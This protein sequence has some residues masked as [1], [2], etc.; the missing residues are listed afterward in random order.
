MELFI[1]KQLQ[2]FSN[3]FFDMFFQGITILGEE[4][5]ILLF[6]VILYW[7]INKDLGKF[8]GYTFFISLLINTSLKEFFHTTRPIGIDGIRSLRTSTAIGYSFPSGH[9]QA[10]TTLFASLSIYL[11]RRF[12]YIVSI[13]LIVFVGISRV[14]LGLHWPRDVIGAIIIALIIVLVSYHTYIGDHY[15]SMLLSILALGSPLIIYFNDS[16]YTKSYGILLG[17]FLGIVLE[18]KYVNFTM[19][20]NIK[21]NIL[22][23]AFG[24]IGLF[25][26]K[27][28]FKFIL[29]EHY[30]SDTLRYALISFYGIGVFPL[31]IKKFN[32]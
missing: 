23:V 12:V 30:F 3:S 8:I 4:T 13:I 28:G 7:T 10:F 26:I 22:R 18:K 6:F 17:Y 32:I 27:E 9:T 19:T 25:L 16:E 20:K 31:L 14:Y 1:I 15:K 11:K 5:F 29:P 21:K 2:S 24:L